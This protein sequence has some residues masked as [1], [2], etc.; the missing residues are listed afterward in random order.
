MNKE[1]NKNEKPQPGRIGS[2]SKGMQVM[3]MLMCDTSSEEEP[4]APPGC[5][6]LALNVR[7]L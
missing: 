2:V 1:C 4:V 3:C 6:H 7:T 5:Q